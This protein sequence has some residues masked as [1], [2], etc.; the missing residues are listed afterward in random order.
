[1]AR[2]VRIEFEN[3][4]YHV[5]ARGNDRQS[6]FRDDAD[7]RRFL[8]TLGQACERF[9]L[10]VHA[11]CLMPNHYHL[12]ASTPRANLSRAVGWLQTTYCIRYNRRHA[13][14]GHLVQG[15]FKAHLIDADA[16]AKRL[17]RYVHLNPV[18][19][20]DRR[21][22]VPVERRKFFENYAWSSHRAYASSRGDGPE[23]LSTE[24]LSYWSDGTDRAR[25]RRAYAADVAGCFGQPIARPLDDLKGGLVLGDD[26]LW[27]KVRNAIRG[28]PGK[29]EMRWL[30]RDN[31][32]GARK[33]VRALI[34]DE[35]DGRIQ[36]WARVRL[37][38]EP[39][40]ALGRELGYADGSGVHRVA[41]RIEAAAKSDENLKKRL[42][43]LKK[44]LMS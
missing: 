20:R 9:G 37:A 3:A 24:W 22:P 15:R 6:I 7:R 19:P 21:K 35:P 40:S 25:A 18:R 5:T 4:A 2:P 34:S 43:S 39:M 44:S 14:D 33:K 31:D 36:I 23:W 28:R 16:Y 26:S 42:E 17:V 29:D 11:Y 8:E 13:R 27:D 38:G 10:V 30:K 41:Q 12:L 32:S 1:M